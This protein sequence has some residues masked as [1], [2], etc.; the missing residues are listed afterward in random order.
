MT[1]KISQ[2][3]NV[4]AIQGNVLLP[5]VSNITGT[6]TTVQANLDQLGTYILGTIPTNITT[7][8][9]NA[10]TQSDLII[11]INANVVTANLGMKGY[12]DSVASQS[13]YGN[14]N[15]KSY[16]TG[17]FD[18]N[19]L[20]SANVTYSLGSPTRQWRDLFVSNNT[21]YI[22]GTP[23]STTSGGGLTLTTERN[24][25][26]TTVTTS[27]FGPYSVPKTLTEI[28]SGAPVNVKI[29][30]LDLTATQPGITILGVNSVTASD[31][32]FNV[33]F[34]IEDQATAPSLVG[35]Y[36]V[37][38]PQTELRL[39]NV[40]CV[41]NNCVAF[42][43][44][45]QAVAPYIV[46]QN[47]DLEGTG[48]IP[49]QTIT[50]LACNAASV[51][52]NY[53]TDSEEGFTGN[54]NL[55]AEF[56]NYRFNPNTPFA[57]YNGNGYS[58]VAIASTQTSITLPYLVNPGTLNPL[59]TTTITPHW[60]PV[61]VRLTSSDYS[62]VGSTITI[63]YLASSLPNWS[64][65][66]NLTVWELVTLDGDT[67]TTTDLVA[68]TITPGS[69]DLTVVGDL[70]VTGDLTV[71]PTSIYMGNLRISA[72]DGNL[73]V[74]TGIKFS[75]D[76]VQSTAYSNV[77]VATYLPTYTGNIANI[78][79]SS[80]GVLTFADGTTQTTAGI[81][82]NVQV[83]TYLPSYSGNIG[84]N[85]GL[86]VTNPLTVAGNITA[87]YA[88]P[89]ASFAN[90]IFN[91][92]GLANGFAQLN[93]QN[94][95]SVGTQNSADFIATAPNGTDSSRYIDMGINGNNYSSS[96]WTVSGKNDGY[97][98]INSGNL[99]LG[100]DTPNTT[101]KVHVGG[102]LAANVV[103]T[104]SNSNV[105]IGGNLIVGNT[106]V[107]TA[108]NSVGSKGQISYDSSYVYV[109]IADNNWRRANLAIW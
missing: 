35:P 65:G 39:G 16:L 109:C 59:T 45:A 103:A 27:N 94:V 68:E 80:S 82:S 97:V 67:I 77:K 28:P 21:I 6:L 74:N 76:S 88:F 81:Y 1:I 46:T 73:K 98:Y 66:G 11:G 84:G 18:G 32:Y 12:V 96:A 17:G 53:T 78:R 99:T 43:Q 102:T 75:D 92:G 79:L 19:I 51:T 40:S 60:E 52:F 100:T 31:G 89:T 86:F 22:G 9:T 20:P 37:S 49:Q 47:V 104:F 69:G 13:I 54:I 87:G 107:P 85:G 25:L 57:S 7:L 34:E 62:I 26:E 36:A 8:Q 64:G 10:A 15:V 50:V 101:V 2:L 105:T 72:A 106:Y 55:P 61:E 5:I 38:G 83:S 23:L 14:S 41:V 93:I 4:A 71:S 3:G 108:N 70:T 48:W 29:S 91:G 24:L 33:E 58:G 42:F 30:Y 44:T 90:V 63:T 95:D 56:F